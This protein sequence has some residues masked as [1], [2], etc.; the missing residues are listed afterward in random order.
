VD[1]EVERDATALL[2]VERPLESEV[3]PLMDVLN[4]LE[5]EE[6]T[7]LVVE[8]PVD[9]EVEREATLLLVVLATE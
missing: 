1:V 9:A 7:L 4:P 8:R 2:V 3:M 6:T 5:R